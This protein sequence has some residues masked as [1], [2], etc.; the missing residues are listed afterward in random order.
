MCTR[1]PVIAEKVQKRETA[2]GRA[3]VRRC[4]EGGRRAAEKVAQI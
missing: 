3:T 2:R 1:K 4:V